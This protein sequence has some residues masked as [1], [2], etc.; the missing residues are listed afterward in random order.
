[1][2]TSN[3]KIVCLLCLFIVLSIS[4]NKDINI[5]DYFGEYEF[6]SFVAPYDKIDEKRIEE[7]TNSSFN[8]LFITEDV[9]SVGIWNKNN[10]SYKIAYP[11]NEG[12]V[13]NQNRTYTCSYFIDLL[14]ENRTYKQVIIVDDSYFVEIINEKEIAIKSVGGWF[15]YKK[16]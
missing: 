4:C 7:L 13:E 1:M 15:V 2:K 11:D 12:V 10:P 14:T 16:E 5:K 8:K 9:F 6:S 3:G